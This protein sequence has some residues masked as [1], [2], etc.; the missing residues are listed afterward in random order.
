MRFKVYLLRHRGRRLTWRDVHNGPSYTGHLVTH[1]MKTGE[2]TYR[3]L[4][5]RADD[6]M[7]PT[8]IPPLFEPAL[9]GFAPLAFRLRGFERVERAGGTFAVVQEWHCELP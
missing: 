3:V 9:L 2:E 8:P 6:P 1:E 5:L 4:T 7:V